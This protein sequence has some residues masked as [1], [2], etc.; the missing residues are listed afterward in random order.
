MDGL[1][2]TLPSKLRYVKIKL[3]YDCY[4]SNATLIVNQN[5]NDNINSFS[6]LK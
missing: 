2:V 6:T 1:V 5:K 4:H 3:F